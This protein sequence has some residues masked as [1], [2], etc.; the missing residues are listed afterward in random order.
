MVSLLLPWSPCCCHGLLIAVMVSSL[1]TWS[2]HCCH[3]LLI[4]DMVSSLPTWSPHCRHG[5]LAAV[6]VSSL[7]TWSPCCC[8][9]LLAADMVSLL[10]S[11]SP[12]CRHGLLI[13]AMVSQ[14][15]P[16]TPHC[17]HGFLIAAMVSLLLSRVSLLPLGHPHYNQ[18][19]PAVELS[20]TP[21]Q[22]SPR[23]PTEGVHTP[24]C[25]LLPSGM[26]GQST[27]AYSSYITSPAHFCLLEHFLIDRC[28][29]LRATGSH[30]HT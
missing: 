14:L 5:L 1:P 4:A 26:S 30:H 15:P 8:H 6:M 23:P 7:L 19:L 24:D 13:A 21:P 18:G 28:V 20:S 25:P 16:W 17:H 29:L 12:H 2:P 27:S 22:Y 10:L 11:W 9:G 3:G